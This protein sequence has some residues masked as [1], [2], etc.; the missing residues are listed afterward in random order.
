MDM[1]DLESD[2]GPGAPPVSWDVAFAEAESHA[3]AP[4]TPVAE[5]PDVSPKGVLIEE[6]GPDD[7]DIDT[8]VVIEGVAQRPVSAVE[9][10]AGVTKERV[11]VLLLTVD[12]VDW[13]LVEL[14]QHESG[15]NLDD[16]LF[17]SGLIVEAETA[18]D[19]AFTRDAQ[20]LDD[21]EVRGQ[22]P[23]EPGFILVTQRAQLDR[24]LARRGVMDLDEEC[25]L[26]E[27]LQ[28]EIDFE[29]GIDV[30]DD[31]DHGADRELSE[32]DNTVYSAGDEVDWSVVNFKA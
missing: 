17:I 14:P 25:F 31:Y 11:N 18:R 22:Q 8:G 30:F 27:A 12:G 10:A 2:S 9:R 28:D 13:R 6:G 24:V 29:G 5:S 16:E 23:I 15:S 20:L 26:V 3:D 4:D 32:D 7:P 19:S 1:N 21:L